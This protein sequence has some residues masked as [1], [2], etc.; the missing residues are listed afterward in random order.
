MQLTHIDLFS[1]AGGIATGFH[2]AG[3]RTLAAVEIVDSCV[4]TYRVNHPDVPVIHSDIRKVGLRDLDEVGALRADLVTAGMPCETFSTAGSTSRSFYDRRQVLYREAIRIAILVHAEMIV[5]ENVPALLTKRIKKESTTLIIDQIRRD[6][7][8]AGFVRIRE[9]VLNSADYGVPQNRNRLFIIATR[10]ANFFDIPQA[11]I[12]H[13]S[14]TQ[15][16][17]DLPEVRPNGKGTSRKAVYRK[18][19]NHYTTTMRNLAFW[20]TSLKVPNIPTYHDSPNHRPA[21]I[22][23][24][25]HIKPGEGLKELFGKFDGKLRAELQA[26][27]VLPKKWYIQRNRRLVGRFKAPTVTSHCLDEFVH[28]RQDRALTVREVARLQSFPDWYD[29][30][31]GPYICPHKY[32]QQDK[33]EQLGDSVPPLLAHAVGLEVISA[34]EKLM[35]EARDA[36]VA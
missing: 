9:V 6:L 3:I 30:A 25:R 17:T 29:I 23:R 31:G 18:R 24:Y 27:N 19:S 10:N 20:K 32:F 13:T 22:E 28:P 12:S 4:D 34:F 16:F 21:T 2:A 36:S 33:Y 7:A 15:A 1:G 14:I 8:K 5:L 11:I 26:R 35:G